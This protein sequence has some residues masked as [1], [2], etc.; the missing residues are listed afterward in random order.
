MN[1]IKEITITLTIIFILSISI[2]II[3]KI[4]YWLSNW[5]ETEKMLHFYAPQ[6]R[7]TDAK[8]YIF[9]SLI[10]WGF[11]GWL[12][13]AG[14]STLWVWLLTTIVIFFLAITLLI[15]RIIASILLSTWSLIVCAYWVVLA[16]NHVINTDWLDYV[17]V[18]IPI[19]KVYATATALLIVAR[20]LF[21]FSIFLVPSSKAIFLEEVNQENVT[22]KDIN[23]GILVKLLIMLISPCCLSL[24]FG[25]I[26]SI[27]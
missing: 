9:P 8:G 7:F 14:S 18:S 10:Y 2:S 16:N 4:A 26:I 1:W 17:N 25:W 20:L 15:N 21:G 24:V 12:F 13:S 3:T 6:S 23:F 19:S 11:Q 27:F 5:E 22:I